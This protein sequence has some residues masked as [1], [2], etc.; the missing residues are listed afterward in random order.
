MDQN[1]YNSGDYNSGDYNSGDGNSGHYNSGDYNS[2]FFNTTTPKVRLFNKDSDL[3]FDSD[4]VNKLRNLNVKPILQWVYE[5]DMT[6]DEKENNPSYKTTG[7][8]LKNTGKNDWSQLSDDEKEFIK[9]LP[10]Y[11]ADIFFVITGVRL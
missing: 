6:E 1:N 7:G 3:D 2:G 4:V 8:Y 9:S 5:L 11:D 10:N